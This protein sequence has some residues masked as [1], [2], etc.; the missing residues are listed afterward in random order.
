MRTIQDLRKDE[1]AVHSLKNRS[2]VIFVILFILI[3]SSSFKL[4]QLTIIERDSYKVESEKNR[5]IEIPIYPSRGLIT[6]EDGT[7]I[8]ENIVTQG[9]FIRNKFLES[10]KDQIEVLFRDVLEEKRNFFVSD[11]TKE[12]QKIWLAKDLTVKELA[13]YELHK[14]A[15][16]NL[17]L[18]TNLRR[19]LPHQSLF[20]H[21]I[22]HLGP[23]DREERLSLSKKE[24][25]AGSYLSLIHI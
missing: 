17:E 24:Y 1:Q 22:G 23:I 14:N 7:I 21:V 16:V 18:G 15:L 11:E 20:S 4:F 3:L 6:L 9:I 25:P 10:S 19:Y 13:K 2:K 5:I 8:A 12:G